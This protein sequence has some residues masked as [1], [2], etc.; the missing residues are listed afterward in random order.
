[1]TTWTSQQGEPYPQGV[2]WI[3]AER[4][5]NF[6]I[7]SKHAQRVELLFYG[8]GDYVNPVHR[9]TL[10]YLKNKTHRIWHCRIPRD[11]IPDARYYA[12]RISGPRPQDTGGWQWF[13]AEKILLDP[14][15]KSVFF[16]PGFSRTA[17]IAPGANAGQAAL[18]CLCEGNPPFDWQGTTAP[19][20]EGDLIVYEMHVKGF[21]RLAP[22]V[23]NEARGTFAGLVEKIPY[24]QA[25]GVTAVEL[26]PVHQFD[27]QEG[28][29]WGYMTM[30]FFSPHHLYCATRDACDQ[31]NEFKTMVRELHRADIEVIMDVV[32]NHT[33]EGDHQG[34]IYSYRGIDNSTYYLLNNNPDDPYCN[35]TECGNT[36]NCENR[37]TR[38]LI[39][40]CLRYWVREAKVDGFRFDL[41]SIFTRN[42]DGSVNLDDPAVIGEISSDPDLARIRLIAEPWDPFT[43]ELGR[44]FPGLMW[45]QWNDQFRDQTRRFVKSDQDLVN[46][47]I[48]R[49]Y[50]SDDIFSDDLMNAYLSSQSLNYVASHDGLTLYD[51]VAYNSPSSWNCGWEGEAGVPAEVMAL[52]KRQVKNFITLLMLSNGTPMFRMGD[53]FLNTQNGWENPYNQDNEISWLQWDRLTTHGDVFDFFKG[54]IAF[55]KAHR[56]IGRNRYWREDVR[57]YGANGEVDRSPASRSLAYYLNGASQGDDD[58][59]V[60]INAYWEQLTFTFQETGPW[61]RIINTGMPSPHDL[62]GQGDESVSTPDYRVGPRS[63]AVFVRP[64]NQS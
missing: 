39:L 13:D 51:L 10:D 14:Y 35:F 29:Y 36:T 40:D 47:M 58:I 54:V 2:T 46:Q 22:D 44:N 37:Q 26:M 4:A 7:Y 30:N 12:Y 1:M 27:P 59:Y 34:P 18:G 31:I 64:G 25:L 41:A 60:M 17:A 5:F 57:W 56:S 21:S 15:A 49:L 28:S 63:I 23:S 45:M 32:F 43:Y 11:R 8:D 3:E 42:P 6:S 48:T 9:Y 50:G 16:P 62:I 52:R 53:E 33:T 61:L 55:R 20:H 24:L 19:R 38:R